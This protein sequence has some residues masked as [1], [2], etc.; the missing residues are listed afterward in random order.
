VFLRW[1]FV[2][3]QSYNDVPFHNFRHAFTVMQMVCQAPFN[4][5][6]LMACWLSV[7]INRDGL[8]S[9]VDNSGL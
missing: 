4:Y 3:Y 7:I 6:R 1:L 5:L 8:C 2:I 9:V